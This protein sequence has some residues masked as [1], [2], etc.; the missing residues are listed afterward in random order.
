MRAITPVFA[1]FL[2]LLLVSGY[3]F[4]ELPATSA[5]LLAAAPVLGLIPTGRLSRL[6]AA[7]I[8]VIL[9]SLPVVAG[10]IVA[11]LASPPLDY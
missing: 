2:G 1:L 9:V 11:L 5:L 4:A 7:A 3:F 8:R 10:V 6:S